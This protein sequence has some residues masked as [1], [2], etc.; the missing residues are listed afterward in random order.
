[1]ITGVPSPPNSYKDLQ[2]Q[3]ADFEHREVTDRNRWS[4]TGND[5]RD[6]LKASFKQNFRLTL[7]SVDCSYSIRA[8][9]DMYLRGD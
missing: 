6:K 9:L 3:L 8:M 1:M 2:K 7:S 4:R 5:L